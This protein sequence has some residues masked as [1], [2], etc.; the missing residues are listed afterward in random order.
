AR[1]GRA[2]EQ[3]PNPQLNRPRALSAYEKALAR[4]PSRVDV[5]RRVAVLTLELGDP[6]AARRHVEVLL[7]AYPQQETPKEVP[8]GRWYRPHRRLVVPAPIAELGELQLLLGRC[9]ED[10]DRLDEA[11]NA[12]E[13]A[14]AN[15][16][17][18]VDAYVRLAALHR[19]LGRFERA[20][21][22]LFDLVDANPT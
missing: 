10:E 18:C 22:V 12:Y 19:R 17:H 15:T 8:A 4:D 7:K 2:L 5:R 9:F 3:L 14:T 6:T 13:S 21:D 20:D 1:Y 16:P 11:R